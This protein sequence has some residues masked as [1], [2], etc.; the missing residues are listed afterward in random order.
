M[1]IVIIAVCAILFG[2]CLWWATENDWY[3][4]APGACVLVSGI[5]LVAALS[6]GIWLWVECSKLSVIDERIAMYQEENQ[7]I[8]EQI[9]VAIKNYQDHEADIFGDLKPESAITLIT[10]YPELKSDR[11]VQGQLEVYVENNAEIKE[12]RE[13]K[14][15]GRVY[16]WWGYFGK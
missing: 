7:T 6:V 12:L 16:R 5:L 15:M 10:N 11:L 8:E 4:E 2:L 13:A 1:I 14:I 9:S 3:D